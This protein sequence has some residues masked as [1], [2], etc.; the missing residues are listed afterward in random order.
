MYMGYVWQFLKPW[1]LLLLI[2]FSLRTI[3]T[4]ETPSIDELRLQFI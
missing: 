2:L 4:I 1:L 3:I